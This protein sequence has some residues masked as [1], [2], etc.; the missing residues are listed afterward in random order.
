MSL[1]TEAHTWRWRL[2]R[3]DDAAMEGQ[4]KCTPPESLLRYDSPLYVGVEP[5]E[6]LSGAKKDGAQSSQL[7]DM[8]NS[9]LPPRYAG[10]L[11]C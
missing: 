5:L 2:G 6:N 9:M 11:L 8:L 4:V 3:R 10:R 1:V 7:D